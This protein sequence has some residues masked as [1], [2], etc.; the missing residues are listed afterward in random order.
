MTDLSANNVA[1]NDAG[2]K[3]YRIDVHHHYIPPK[4]YETIS[5]RI[6]LRP[7]LRDWTPART[8]ED[9]D[10]AGIEVA[11][12]SVTTPGLWFGDVAEARRL[13][14]E[15]NDYAAR[16]VSDH[17]KRFRQWVALPLPDLEG[18]LRELEYG[19][20]QLKALGAGVFTNY[21]EK[22]LGNALFAPLMEELNRRKAVLYTHPTVCK[23]C[24]DLQTY[25]SEAVIEYGTDT[26]RAIASMLF[27]GTAA[28]YSD[29]DVVFS[30][31]G[32]TMPYLYERFI[33][34]SQ[35]PHMARHLP[36]GLD[37][38][39]NKFHYDTAQSSNAAVTACLRKIVSV[40]QILFGT[41]FPYRR[42]E[43]HVCGLRTC[44]Y[45]DEELFEIE[46]SNALRLLP[47]L[48]AKT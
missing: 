13:A 42:G 5:D 38:E 33:L 18:S 27:T 1:A 6:P 45:T 35:L 12:L 41:D 7:V 36:K 43:E 31:S 23:C 48:R 44:G 30:H 40:P 2:G 4:Y 24:A 16:M 32:G 29:I 47:R 46:R 9:M 10:K 21:S 25:L 22:Y 17:P 28:K 26:T 8:L 34:V 14:R 19:L 20:D 37:Y 39:I 15:C 11:I 3:P